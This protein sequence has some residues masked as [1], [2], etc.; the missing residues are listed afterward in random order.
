[1]HLKVR[2]GKLDTRVGEAHARALESLS[3][4]Q[5]GAAAGLGVR[6]GVS[7]SKRVNIS[8]YSTAPRCG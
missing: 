6:R 1:M 7:T 3:G 5:R 8:R 2:L 4:M